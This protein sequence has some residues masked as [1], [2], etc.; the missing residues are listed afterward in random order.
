MK[1]VPPNSQAWKALPPS[2]DKTLVQHIQPGGAVVEVPKSWEYPEVPP[3]PRIPSP[4]EYEEVPPIP[5]KF[6][7]QAK[8]NAVSSSRSSGSNQPSLPTTELRT[9]SP[10]L[11]D[12]SPSPSAAFA[13]PASSLHSSSP[14][15]EQAP[16]QNY[17]PLAQSPHSYQKPGV[18]VQ[19]FGAN[20]ASYFTT[21]PGYEHREEHDGVSLS[22]SPAPPTPEDRS[23]ASRS[24]SIDLDASASLRSPTRKAQPQDT[25]Q[26]RGDYFPSSYGIEASATRGRALIPHAPPRTQYYNHYIESDQRYSLSKAIARRSSVDD[27]ED[28]WEDEDEKAH[29]QSLA[30][31]YH[32]TLAEQYR[33]LCV[34]QPGVFDTEWNNDPDSEDTGRDIKLVPEPLFYKPA[35]HIQRPSIASRRTEEDMKRDRRQSSGLKAHLKLPSLSE[36]PLKL[37]LPQRA[38]RN[39]STTGFIPIS[40][41]FDKMSYPAERKAAV[42][43]IRAATQRRRNNGASARVF[44]YYPRT[45]PATPPKAKVKIRGKKS[46]TQ[47]EHVPP[48]KLQLLDFT[49]AIKRLERVLATQRDIIKPRKGPSSPPSS[50][51]DALPRRLPQD[52]RSP[53]LSRSRSPAR[54]PHVP[55]DPKIGHI[56]HDYRQKTDSGT[57]L[58]PLSPN[59]SPR[60]S[61]SY[62]RPLPQTPDMKFPKLLDRADTPPQTP[63]LRH[64]R[65]GSRTE[66]VVAGVQ[67]VFHRAKK[68][69]ESTHP[70]GSGGG[71]GPH[72]PFVHEQRKEPQLQP[73][74]QLTRRETFPVGGGERAEKRSEKR[75]PLPYRPSLFEKAM[76]ARSEAKAAKR[77]EE[78]KK[79]IRVVG[80]GDL[81]AAGG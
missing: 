66:K 75:S 35:V 29:R 53:G 51:P 70:A 80:R 41:P 72:L 30:K 81:N 45:K 56:D 15:E 25:V 6:L 42:S 24:S 3:L 60:L 64:K 33:D 77:R 57:P 11:P 4:W 31:E 23:T 55:R 74:S 50:S 5:S 36:G 58:Y 52:T 79:S 34:P 59:P 8:A 73:Q 63:Q 26:D 69:I 28:E 13:R 37:A 19:D 67:Q 62:D 43:G 9:Y 54:R 65:D 22:S 10:L 68:S 27:A 48:L 61:D 32:S 7:P 46:K 21:R 38:R 78:I 14:I 49:D 17:P 16:T 1:I 2:P 39:S 47:T 18:Q 20:H 76:G 40:P 12:P 71:G 44:A